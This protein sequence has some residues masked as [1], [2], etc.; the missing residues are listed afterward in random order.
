MGREYL[1]EMPMGVGQAIGIRSVA[2][3]L[4]ELCL[5]LFR[6]PLELVALSPILGSIV[7]YSPWEDQRLINQPHIVLIMEE[8]FTVSIAG[9]DS[10]PELDLRLQSG[11]GESAGDLIQGEGG[12]GRQ[13]GG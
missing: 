3:D 13:S 4:I 10:H 9:E 8:N 11:R 7:P 12:R 6:F 5:Q 1:D 2:P